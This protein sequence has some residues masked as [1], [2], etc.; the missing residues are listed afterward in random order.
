M[1]VFCNVGPGVGIRI[2]GLALLTLLV[3]AC[4]GCPFK[5]LLPMSVPREHDGGGVHHLPGLFFMYC[6]QTVKM[7]ILAGFHFLSF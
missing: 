6:L 5:G 7:A 1:M 3:L 4:T 2:L